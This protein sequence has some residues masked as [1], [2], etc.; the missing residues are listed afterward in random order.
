MTTAP[1]AQPGPHDDIPLIR[2]NPLGKDHHGEAAALR[3][4]GRATGGVV[5][6]LLPGGLP[7]WALTTHELVRWLVTDAPVSKNYRNWSAVREGRLAPDNPI[8]GMVMVDNLVT[9]DGEDHQRLRR[10]IAS[11]MTRR[12]TELLAPRI[13]GIATALLDELP[14]HTDSRGVV[15]LRAHY[16]SQL[17]LRVICELL[18]VPAADRP[19]MRHLVDTIFRTD[20]TGDQVTRAQEAIPGFLNELIELRTRDRGDDL[21]SALITDR[22]QGR[23]VMTDSE[24]A[25]TLWVMATAGHETTIS[26]TTNTIRALLAH[27]DQLHQVQHGSLTWPTVIAEIL[28]WDPPIGNF[29]G[30]YPSADLPIPGTNV[31]IGAGEAILAPYTAVGRDPIHHGDDAHLFDPARLQQ[32]DLAFGGGPHTCPGSALAHLETLTAVPLLFDRHPNL[33]LAV[34]ADQLPP[35]ASIFTN[36]AAVLPTHLGEPT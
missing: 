19:R 30:R 32:G 5:R 3:D 29:I 2:L 6:V 16:T 17:P 24:L 11:H 14:R 4:A 15:D 22:E 36:S 35:M 33:R 23:T 20:T 18:G 1:T 12:R 34:P 10:P 25:G 28:R 27:P 31:I 8:I 21:T 7:A 9:A 13:T 26:L